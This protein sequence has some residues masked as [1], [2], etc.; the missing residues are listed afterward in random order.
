MSGVVVIGSSGGGTATLGHTDPV[1]L[2]TTIH[3][4]LGRI[5]TSS[6]PFGISYAL[7]VSCPKVRNRQVKLMNKIDFKT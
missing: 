2:L 4:E 7:F 1:E 6:E 5:Q 3:R